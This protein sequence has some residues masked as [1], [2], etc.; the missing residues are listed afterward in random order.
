MKILLA[1]DGS[2]NA[3]EAARFLTRFRLS[4]RDEVLIVHVVSEVPFED[5]YAA[6]VKIAIRRVAPRI[7][8]ETA[9]ILKPAGTGIKTIEREGY[10]DTA[11][12]ETATEA[13]SDLIV[14][15]A[16][17][18]KGIQVFFLGSSTR[19]VAGISPLPLLVV[20]TPPW[21]TPSAMKVLFATDGSETANAAGRF[22]ALL[23]LPEET[24]ITVMH[25]ALSP[26]LDVPEKFVAELREQIGDERSWIRTAG[27]GSAERLLEQARAYLGERFSKISFLTRTGDPSREIL[28]AEKVIEADLIVLGCRGL[29]GMKGILGSVSRRVLGHS[30]S[31]VLIGKACAKKD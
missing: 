9:G 23:P 10:P 19:A 18:V 26:S 6:R 7:L 25:T 14:M 11:I 2:E 12:I 4:P 1:T 13:E 8:A 21:K 22:L 15:G 31:S 17:G 28:E 30:A 20:K 24:E 16:R 5:D 29:R 27:Y 3:E